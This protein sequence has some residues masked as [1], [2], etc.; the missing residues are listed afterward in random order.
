MIAD[1]ELLLKSAWNYNV[2]NR[3]PLIELVLNK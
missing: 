3:I 2:E 1:F